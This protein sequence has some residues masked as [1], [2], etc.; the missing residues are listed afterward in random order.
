MQRQGVWLRKN[1][2]EFL[3]LVSCYQNVPHHSLQHIVSIDFRLRPENIVLYAWR[4]EKCK[5]KSLFSSVLFPVSPI[6]GFSNY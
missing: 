1:K 5:Q 2:L 3:S 4:K 6:Y